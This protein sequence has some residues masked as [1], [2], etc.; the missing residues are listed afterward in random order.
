M[1]KFGYALRGEPPI[2]H[3]FLVH[4]KRVSAIAA[5]STEGLVGVEL[6]TGTV[7][8]ELFADFVLGTLIPEMEPFDGS[9]KKSIAI[10]DNCSI[11]HNTVIKQHFEDA[12]ILVL[13]L[14]PYS[15]DLMPIGEAFSSLS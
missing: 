2:Y 7:N 1:S 14:P 3:H 10:M 13:F 5:I 6:T 12:G 11:H 4:G 9:A 15:P 8:S